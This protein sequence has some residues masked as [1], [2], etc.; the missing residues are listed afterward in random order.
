MKIETRRRK[1]ADVPVLEQYA[2][3]AK[4][5]L[6]LQHGIFGDKDR[7]ARLFASSFAK[8]GYHVVSV[9]ARKHGARSEEPFLAKDKVESELELFDVVE[10]TARD[11]VKTH[12]TVFAEEYPRFD[13]LGVSMGAYIAYRTSAL[14]ERVETLIALLGSP[15]FEATA[16]NGFTEEDHEKHRDR[17]AKEQEKIRCMNPARDPESL[18]FDR[19]ILLSGN[20]DVVIP[21]AH[22][23]RFVERLE[24]KDV[25][26][27]TYD[28][29]H[30]IVRPMHKDLL[31]LLE[32]S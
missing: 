8:K 29:G 3:N 11:I 1:I 23:A 13:I 19:A 7:I 20:D 10:K 27:R 5:L 22:T 2:K 30:R 28:T 26:F 16:F 18:T 17:I 21:P 31:E 32:P 24:R 15:D 6:Y 12:E 9:D 4:K 14:T 25:V